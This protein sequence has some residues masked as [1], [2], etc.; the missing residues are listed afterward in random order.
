MADTERDA[1]LANNV[2]QIRTAVYGKDVRK[3]IADS[4]EMCYTDISTGKTLADDATAAA[5]EAAD[6]ASTNADA[7][8]QAARGVNDIV[9]VQESQPDSSTN[10]IWIKPE[11]DEYK[12][13]TWEEFNT[14]RSDVS[15]GNFDGGYVD[16]GNRLHLTKDNYD[17]DNFEPVT[18]PT[19]DPGLSFDGG[20]V[21]E[22]DGTYYL[23]LT[24]NG[25]DIEGFT[26]IVVPATGGGGGGGGSSDNNAVLTVQN[27]TGWL[28]TTIS[29]NSDLFLSFTWSSLEDDTPT[30]DGIL[31]ILKDN[32]T[33]RT[34]T[35]QQGQVSINVRDV[36]SIGLNRIRFKITDVYGNSRPINFSI[37]VVE[38]TIT[39]P[40]NTDT[41]YSGDMSFSYVASGGANLLKTIYLEL[42]GSIY[43]TQTETDSGR[44]RRFNISSLSHGSHTLRCWFE[45]DT[46]GVTVMSNVLA[47]DFVYVTDSGTA[48]V[49]SSNFARDVVPQYSSVLIDYLVYTPKYLTSNV[50]ISLNGTVV[51]EQTVDRTRHQYSMRFNDT[52]ENTVTFTSNGTTKTLTVNVEHIDAA[53]AETEDLKLYLTSFGRSNN[54]SEST[55]NTW[56]DDTNNIDAVMT[57]FNFSSDGWMLDND[58]NAILRVSGEARVTIPYKLFGKDFKA[59]GKTIEIEFATRSVLDYD[60]TIIS[61]LSNGIGFKMTPQRA[62][63]TAAHS[64]IS[65]QYKED[66]HVRLSFV[67]QKI[68]EDNLILVFVNGIPSGVVQY[69]DSEQF[70]QGTP[71]DIS[72]GSSLCATDIYCIR[73]YDN[74]LTRKQILNNYIADI[75]DVDTMIAKFDRNNVYDGDS[76]NIVISKLPTNLPYFIFDAEQLPQYKGD[77][78]TITGTYVDPMHPSNSFTFTGCQINV[79][80]TSSAPYA[81]KNYDLQFKKGFEMTESGDHADNFAL[82]ST[83]IPFNRFVT[84][85]DVASSEGANNVELVKLYCEISPYKTREM[86]ADP[87]VRQGIYGFPIVIFW[88]DLTTDKISFLGKYNFNLPKRAPAPYGYHDDMESWEFQLNRDNLMLFKSD[89]FDMTMKLDTASGEEKE[90]WRF[91]YEARFPDDT[92]VNITKLQAFQTFVVSTN[93]DAA[94]GNSLGKSVTYDGVTYTTD[95]AEYRLAKFKNEF[96]NI[97]EI[98]SFIFYYVFTEF[99][100]MTDSRAKNLFIGF[101]GS[102]VDQSL[103]YPIDRKAV[104]EP[105]DM[106]TGLGTN[107]MGH[108]TFTFSLEDTDHDEHGDMIFNGQDST[109]WVNVRDAFGPEIRQMYQTL[110]S[111]NKFNYD[112]IEKKF[113]DHQSV[114]PE[115]VWIED[116]WFKYI[117]PLINPDPGKEPDAVYLPMMQ[118]SKTEQRKW[119]LYNR[120]RYMDSKWNAGDALDDVITVRAY[121]RASITVTPYA[122]I[123]PTVKYASYTVQERGQH[124]VATTLPIPDQIPDAQETEI[125]IYSASQLKSVGD[126][127]GLRVGFADFSKAIRLQSI[128]LGD[129][130]QDYTNTSLDYLTIGTNEHLTTLDVRHCPSL[131]TGDQKSLDLSK[132]PNLESV[133]LSGTSLTSVVFANGGVLK[134]VELPTTLTSLTVRNQPLISSFSLQGATHL[135]SLWVENAGPEVKAIVYLANMPAG[136]AVRIIDFPQTNFTSYNEARV[137]YGALDK[138]KGLDEYGNIVDEP[139]VSGAIHINRLTQEQYDALRDKYPNITLTYSLFVFEL[140][141][142]NEDGT[143]ELHRDQFTRPGDGTWSATPSKSATVEHVYVFEGWSLTPGGPVDSNAT[144]R[145]TE[146]RT[147]YA[148]YEERIREYTVT[149]HNNEGVLQQSL[150]GYGEMPAYTGSTPQNDGVEDPENYEFAGWYPVIHKVVTTTDYAAAYIYTASKTRAFLKRQYGTD[151]SYDEIERISQY[152][153]CRNYGLKTVSIKNATRISSYAFSHCVNLESA[154][155]PAVTNLDSSAFDDCTSL[156]TVNVPLVRNL[157]GYQ[158]R[159]CSS[160]ESI[161]LPSATYLG[162]YVFSDCTNLS[163]VY[164]PNVTYI[165]S[166]CFGGCSKLTSIALPAITGAD[167]WNIH[168]TVFSRC[169]ALTDIYVAFTELDSAAA[170]APWGAPNATVHY[171]TQFDIDGHPII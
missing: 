11:S 133:Y 106:D 158:F 115:A 64:E 87:K 74:D 139:Q 144:K 103:G 9:L 86:I 165:Y 24:Y 29:A 164:I 50:T 16:S 35:I 63:L 57:N 3:A 10:K 38:F 95:T 126:L 65:T 116:S 52:G 119:W 88:H 1:I 48:T 30:G 14:L 150:V 102:D 85:A 60:T 141:Y 90:A 128:K 132:C 44:Q 49:I 129:A 15:A 166:F 83:V 81:R 91:S 8:E 19:P 153:F 168:S 152:A 134:R 148:V 13:P 104:C 123:Y 4:I 89:Y 25:Q 159:N 67:V 124:D 37:T 92:W 111:G 71:V 151:L 75:R 135:T 79:Q 76:S 156:R 118:G 17:I 32:V 21:A 42:D 58:G 26:P 167:S 46:G 27:T 22:E 47:Y 34:V 121:A 99:F 149:F 62:T 107:N 131:G 157:S 170:N 55:R 101:S 117:D 138:M 18:L 59:D 31:Y 66:D 53:V 78:K 45:A 110:R 77:K 163:S 39:S 20:Y 28:A 160:L 7:A 142:M 147:I 70:A 82:A 130:D 145:V 171:G 23:H 36:L 105:Y 127:S 154:D 136:A 41:I 51:S 72:I 169:Y 114:W 162:N 6:R 94:T 161:S 108:L 98:E 73:V 69:L 137:I 2:S 120:F 93:R 155:L 96:G 143:A 122:D 61:C 5:N 43:D 54:E 146:N 140:I 33:F 12:V 109:L 113:E 84:K 100:L 125:Y 112:Y 80:G 56:R 97:A 68:S 40:F